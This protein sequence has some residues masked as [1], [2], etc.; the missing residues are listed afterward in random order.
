LVD[1]VEDKVVFSMAYPP[2]AVSAPDIYNSEFITILCNKQR[3]H[4]VLFCTD[5]GIV[6]PHFS[7][8]SVVYPS[9]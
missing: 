1:I 7:F 5:L 9:D 4:A 6:I 3:D 2:G 8:S